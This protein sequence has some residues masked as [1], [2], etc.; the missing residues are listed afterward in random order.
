MLRKI[1]E[2]VYHFEFIEFIEFIEL[3]RFILISDMDKLKH[4]HSHAKLYHTFFTVHF[5]C[6][7][8][9]CETNK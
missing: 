9:L 3:I 1:I 4:L 5:V 6:N 7:P 2:T 8:I